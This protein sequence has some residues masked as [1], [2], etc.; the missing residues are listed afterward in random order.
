[1]KETVINLFLTEKLK[2]KEIS[3][4]VNLSKEEVDKIL[5][6]EHYVLHNQRSYEKTILLKQ[7]IDEYLILNKEVG[8]TTI[9]KKYGISHDTLIN[10]LHKLGIEV[11]NNQ[12]RTKFDN[13]VFDI[14]DTEEKAYWLG[15]IYADGYISSSPLN[16]NIKSRYD[17][18]LSL[19]DKDVNHLY[20]FNKFMKHEKDNVKVGKVRCKET[21]CGRCRWSIVNKHLWERLNE[22]G[23]T[24]NKSLTLEFPDESTFKSRDLIRHFIRGYFDGD[25]SLG[26]YQT[27]Y[28]TP[29]YSCD[30]LGTKSFLEKV[31]EYSDIQAAFRH[32]SRHSDETFSFNLSAFR[33]K[34]FL[35]YLYKDCTIYLDRKYI[36]YL[37]ICRSWEKFHESLEGKNGEGCDANTVLNSEIAKG[38]E[39]V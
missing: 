20:K 9:A 10:C 22:I 12:N 5:R 19:S 21:V 18:E 16:P 32:D 39:S 6:S 17:F 38:S 35:D 36:K 4:K 1:M 14:I 27:K 25:G 30:L 31:L 23:C 7:A 15:F 26:L 24:P 2:L 29:K 28:I 37:E 33:T 11:P 8:A 34:K 13:S 3:E